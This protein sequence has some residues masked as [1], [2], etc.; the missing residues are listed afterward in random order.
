MR[1]KAKG[2][3]GLGPGRA[4]IIRNPQTRSKPVPESRNLD[5]LCWCGRKSV[6]VPAEDVRRGRTISCGVKRCVG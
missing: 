2:T 4:T 6:T 3:N 1:R 5:S